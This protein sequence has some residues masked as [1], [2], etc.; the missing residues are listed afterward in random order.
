MLLSWLAAVVL[1]S[2]FLTSSMHNYPGGL[3]MERLLAQHVGVHVLDEIHT[4]RRAK[5]LFVHISVPAAMTGVSRFTQERILRPQFSGDNSCKRPG[6]YLNI[7]PET[8]TS[9]PDCHQ[10]WVLYSK[11]ETREDLT[12]F[13]FI[14]TD[15]PR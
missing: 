1:A 6:S 15:Q 14:I 13:D 8:W 5:P 12:P 7:D 11:N 9:S 2:L 4:W 10:D 3:A